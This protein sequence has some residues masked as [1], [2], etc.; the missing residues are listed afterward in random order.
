MSY[1]LSEHERARLLDLRDHGPAPLARRAQIILLS[2]LGT[3]VSAIA[4]DVALT[5]AQVYHW[6]R[7]WLKRRLDIFPAPTSPAPS[8]TVPAPHPGVEVPRLPLQLRETVGMLPDDPMAEAARKALF[9]HFERMLL[10]EPGTREGQDIEAVHDMRVAT[11]RMRSA[12]RLFKPFFEPGTLR[13]FRRYLRRIALALGEVR[14]RD[15]FLEKALRFLNDHPEIDLSPLITTWEAQRQQAR[16]ALIDQMDGKGF[17][18]FV[19]EFHSFL[20]TPGMGAMPLPSPGDATAYQVRH[21]A[22]RVIYEHYEQVRAYDPVLDGASL[23]TLHA[24][25]IAFKRLRYTMEFFEE[26]LGPEVKLVTKDIKGMQDHLGDLNDTRV[27]G[28]VLR[29]FVDQHNADYSGVPIFLRPDISG[30]LHYA[31]A[32]VAEQEHLLDTFPEAW[33]KFNRDEMRQAIALAVAAL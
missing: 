10:H 11:R 22:P 7:E 1:T 19:T 25:R 33:A 30:V 29:E 15:V 21:I 2:E 8:E 27:V 18:R 9:F 23:L 5:S 26:V 4:A 32:R 13:P 12:L 24:L 14:D 17:G 28:E 6:R 16:C 3:P 20:T 31:R